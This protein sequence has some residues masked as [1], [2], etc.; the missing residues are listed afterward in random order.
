[1]GIYFSK[2]AYTVSEVKIPLKENYEMDNDV[3]KK[4]SVSGKRQMTIPKQFY[5]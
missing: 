2:E 4:I 5:D 1:M 3:V